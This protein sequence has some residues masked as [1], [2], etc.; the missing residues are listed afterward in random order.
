M[1]NST[2]QINIKN[3]KNLSTEYLIK[4]ISKGGLNETNANS[5][6]KELE[7]RIPKKL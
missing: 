5:I 1:K 4:I 6:A 7:N 2:T 3:L